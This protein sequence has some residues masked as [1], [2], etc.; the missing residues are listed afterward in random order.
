[1]AGTAWRLREALQ[2]S[3]GVCRIPHGVALAK[4]AAAVGETRVVLADHSDRS[5]YATWLL[6]HV[7]AQGLSDTLI[8]TVADAEVI[9]TLTAQGV[10]DRR[11]SLTWRLAGGWTCRRAN[12]CA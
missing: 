3:Q 4:Q 10:Q 5:G 1:M 7:I 12:L 2:A 9:A 6:R 8:A 11:Y